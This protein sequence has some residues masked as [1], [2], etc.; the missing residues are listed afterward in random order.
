MM[1]CRT[2]GAVVGWMSRMQGRASWVVTRQADQAYT[3]GRRVVQSQASGSNGKADQVGKGGRIRG[4][5]RG[6]GS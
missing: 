4:Q 3:A 6:Q 1:A 5:S 2:E